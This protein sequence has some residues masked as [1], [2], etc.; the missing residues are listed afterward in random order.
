MINQPIIFKYF[1]EAL[2]LFLG[3][4][5]KAFFAP[6]QPDELTPVRKHK[7]REKSQGKRRKQSNHNQHS[8]HPKPFNNMMNRVCLILSILC[9]LSDF[10]H[11]WRKHT[12]YLQTH[13]NS[14]PPQTTLCL[15]GGGSEIKEYEDGLGPYFQ[16]AYGVTA[17]KGD[18]ENASITILDGSLNDALIKARAQARLL[19]TFFP[20]S[21]P[22]NRSKSSMDKIAIK[23]ILSSEVAQIAERRA[24]KKGEGGSFLIWSAKA[25]SQEAAVAMKR[26]KLKKSGKNVPTLLVCY[27]AQVCILNIGREVFLKSKPTSL[28]CGCNNERPLI[29][30]VDRKFPPEYLHNI[31][32]TR[33]L[34]LA[35]WQ[36]GLIFF[37]SA[38]RNNML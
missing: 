21:K 28:V 36:S 12:Q 15:R 33:H 16:E 1:V 22:N 9:C 23:S 37:V 17:S 3:P 4:L 34:L 35:L 11:A 29:H 31:T 18:E 7:Q 13:I 19:V 20:S 6:R 38:M 25:G 10:G 5:L 24:R 30:P 2:V 8:F 32:A 27:P 26:L 14:A